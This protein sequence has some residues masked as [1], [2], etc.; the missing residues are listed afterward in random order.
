M[1]DDDPMD[2]LCDDLGQLCDD[3]G[4]ADKLR[5]AFAAIRRDG[6]NGRTLVAALEWIAADL[7]HSPLEKFEAIDMLLKLPRGFV[8]IESLRSFCGW[9]KPDAEQPHN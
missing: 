8:H 7:D 6:P 4:V 9:N 2:E 1:S 3:H 5:A